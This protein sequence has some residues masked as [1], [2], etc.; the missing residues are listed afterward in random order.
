[1]RKEPQCIFVA[2]A[3]YPDSEKQ[4]Q[5]VAYQ[6]QGEKKIRPY[7]ISELITYL[8]ESHMLFDNSLTSLNQAP[9][10]RQFVDNIV[11]MRIGK[12][13]LAIIDD[14]ISEFG[15]EYSNMSMSD[16]HRVVRDYISHRTMCYDI[17]DDEPVYYSIAAEA[18][19]A[20]GNKSTL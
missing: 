14:C 17:N 13:I 15:A 12:D 5:F 16:W 9:R 1:M 18:S 19:A 8:E 7:A 6:S 3:I 2:P 11:A 10:I 4:I 20:Y